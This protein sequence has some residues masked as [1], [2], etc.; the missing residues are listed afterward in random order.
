MI[1]AVK[2]SIVVFICCISL[3]AHAQNVQVNNSTNPTGTYKTHFN[4]PSNNKLPQGTIKVKLIAQNKV[5]LSLIMQNGEPL[6][7]SGSLMDTLAYKN[8]LAIYKN[9]EIDTTCRITFHFASKGIDVIQ[10]SKAVDHNCD[11]ANGVNAEG[12][13]Y[14]ESS[15]IP[16]FSTY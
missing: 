14:K 13:Y 4:N 11:F 7:R 12:F 5:V 1:Y 15:Q 3:S 8:H 16:D 9:A 2:N 10:A 6:L